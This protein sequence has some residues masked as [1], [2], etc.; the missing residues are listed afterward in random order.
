VIKN[1]FIYYLIFDITLFYT[2]VSVFIEMEFASFI[3]MEFA[4]FIEMEFASVCNAVVR[5][6]WSVIVLL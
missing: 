3:E 4:S 6:F 5:R 2:E 1:C